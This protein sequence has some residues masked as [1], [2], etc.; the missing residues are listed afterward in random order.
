[1]DGDNSSSR[2]DN[3]ERGCNVFGHSQ[4]NV[5]SDSYSLGIK[6]ILLLYLEGSALPVQTFCPSLTTAP[7]VFSMVFTRGLT[8]W[9]FNNYVIQIVG[10]CLLT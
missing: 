9:K 2:S 10:L 4:G 1:M 8:C 6:T 7:K 3:P 5:L